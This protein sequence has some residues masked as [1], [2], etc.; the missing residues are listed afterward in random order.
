MFSIIVP[1]YVS[2]E[3]V[4]N[5]YFGRSISTQ[6]IIQSLRNFKKENSLEKKLT[7]GKH[8][9]TTS[10]YLPYVQRDQ[11][12]KRVRENVDRGRN[13]ANSAVNDLCANA[14]TIILNTGA[15]ALAGAWRVGEE[16]VLTG[17]AS[18]LIGGI[19]RVAVGTGIRSGSNSICNRI[20]SVGV[21]VGIFAITMWGIVNYLSGGVTQTLT[22]GGYNKLT[23]KN[24]ENMK[25]TNEDELANLK[26]Y[27]MEANEIAFALESIMG[28]NN[29]IS[30]L[31]DIME[32]F[33]AKNVLTERVIDMEDYFYVLA[34]FYENLNNPKN[35]TLIRNKTMKKLKNVSNITY[36]NT[37][38]IS[39]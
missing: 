32:H 24:L 9:R 11:R 8:T 16:G 30:F 4:Q 37:I 21:E 14:G 29:F 15:G 1:A 25:F 13:A 28:R 34:Y 35:T 39:A 5:Y 19:I 26:E 12:R 10:E 3:E 7:G 38:A 2:R 33:E 36:P 17:A 23:I 22:G 27:L 20:V 6:E 18:G 31:N